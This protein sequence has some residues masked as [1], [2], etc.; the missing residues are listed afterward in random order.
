LAAGELGGA[1][2]EFG[3][4]EHVIHEHGVCTKEEEVLVC[5]FGDDDVSDDIAM[6]CELG[7]VRAEILMALFEAIADPHGVVHAAS[8]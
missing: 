7:S 3:E 4:C 2:V 8:G 6:V 1:Y 5:D